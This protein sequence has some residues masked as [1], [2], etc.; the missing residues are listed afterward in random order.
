[1]NDAPTLS[2]FASLLPKLA[3]RGDTVENQY[4][5]ELRDRASKGDPL[6][7]A[8]LADWV[9]P[10]ITKFLYGWTKNYDSTNDVAQDVLLKF[11]KKN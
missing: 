8:T 10:I 7:L 6:A 9:Y 11:H 4:F 5:D 2:G 1:V 3:C